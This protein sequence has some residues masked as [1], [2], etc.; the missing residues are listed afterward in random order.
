[1][2]RSLEGNR[3]MTLFESVV[4]NEEFVLPKQSWII[5]GLTLGVSLVAVAL[6]LS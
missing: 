3:E 2:P 5:P 4:R 6:A 1:M